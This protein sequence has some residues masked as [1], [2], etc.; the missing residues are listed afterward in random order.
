MNDCCKK[1]QDKIADACVF[2][3]EES[4]GNVSQSD[5]KA[6]VLCSKILV[7]KVLEMS[8]PEWLESNK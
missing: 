3:L 6:L 7:E 5:S 4:K 2:M 1:Y 8:F